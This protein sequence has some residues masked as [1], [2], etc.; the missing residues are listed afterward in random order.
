MLSVHLM[1]GH[2]G[3]LMRSKYQANIIRFLTYLWTPLLFIV[4]TRPKTS[5]PQVTIVNKTENSADLEVAVEV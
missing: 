3:H 2:F 5:D 4:I 1:N